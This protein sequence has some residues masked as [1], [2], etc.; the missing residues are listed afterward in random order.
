MAGKNVTRGQMSKQGGREN[1]ATG[2]LAVVQAVL[3]FYSVSTQGG[4][5]HSTIVTGWRI[6]CVRLFNTCVNRG[7]LS[8][9]FSAISNTS[10]FLSS[11]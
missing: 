11:C 4:N 1:R 5:E 10:V 2:V 6:L 7:G 8:V 3:G 9:H